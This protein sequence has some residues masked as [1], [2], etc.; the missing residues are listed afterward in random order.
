MYVTKK[1]TTLLSVFT[2]GPYREK[3]VVHVDQ[4]Y[5]EKVFEMVADKI[6]YQINVFQDEKPDGSNEYYIFELNKQNFKLTRYRAVV[7]DSREL[8]EK[9][10]EQMTKT[11]EPFNNMDICLEDF[12]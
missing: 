4:D 3:V 11:L 10:Y 9:E 12:D 8:T 6:N 7:C 2:G 1:N 5:S